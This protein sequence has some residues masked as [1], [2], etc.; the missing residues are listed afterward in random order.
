MKGD[1]GNG[2]VD[3]VNGHLGPNIVL[4]SGD[5]G[6]LSKSGGQIDNGSLSLNTTAGPGE[7]TFAFKTAGANRWAVNVSDA[8]ESGGDAG[9]NFEL[10]NWTDAGARKSPVLFASRLTGNVGVGTNSLAARLTVNGAVALRN[11]TGAPAASSGTAIVYSEAGQLKVVQSDGKRHTIGSADGHIDVRAHGAKGDGAADDAPVFRSALAALAALGGGTLR[12]PGG[13]Y[14]MD[15]AYG[16]WPAPCLYVK[17]NITIECS[18][19]A[20]IRRGL[21]MGV[22]RLVQNFDGTESNSGHS[23]HSNIRISGGTW[24]GN[25]PAK[26]GAGNMFAF[27]HGKN[28][29]LEHV[30]VIDQPNNHA[31]ELNAIDGARVIA[32]RFEGSV[33][34]PDSPQTTEAIQI[35]GAF[36][37][38]GL[39]GGLPYDNTFSHNVVVDKCHVGSSPKNGAWGALVGSHAGIAGGEYRR[40]IVVN[41]TIADT[42]VYGIR[43][44]DWYESVI[45]NNSIYSAAPST[46]RSG[47]RVTSG[48][49]KCDGVLVTDNVLNNVGGSGY[50]AIEVEQLSGATL[51]G[52]I[53]ISDNIVSAYAG[54]GIRVT[55]DAPQIHMNL[56]RAAKAGAVNGINIIEDGS[57]GNVSLNRVTG[58]VSNVIPAGTV[59]GLNDPTSL[60]PT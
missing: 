1:P 33:P 4:A 44:Y 28:I 24:D 39:E 48:K 18:S 22:N 42:L 9:S 57:H 12:V 38:V 27:A 53:V 36:G 8:A 10:S 3:S 56:I 2:S 15:S 43:A 13:T 37:D 52:G 59:G 21:T 20:T 40:I 11:V 25:A 45:A 17:D 19:G 14:L 55:A 60:N 47:I 49:S 46:Y 26:V 6:A 34:K 54:D 31:V 7:R 32:C 23:G 50:G 41:N 58:S 30:R 29:T 16:S 35:D 51:A 5:V